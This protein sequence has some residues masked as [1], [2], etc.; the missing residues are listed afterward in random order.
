MSDCSLSAAARRFAPAA[1]LVIALML[2]NALAANASHSSGIHYHCAVTCH[3]FVH[4][5]ST[6]DNSWFAR[7]EAG[8][9]TTMRHCEAW[10]S[11]FGP[12]PELIGTATVYGATG[13]C[14][15]WVNGPDEQAGYGE[16][17]AE[18][19][20]TPVMTQHAHPVES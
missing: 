7:V 9:S 5:S 13:T 16:Y 4:G 11:Q 20:G 15:Y 10:L 6:T 3:G 17:Y 12:A 2:T 18:S 14:N 19:N 1:A 8:G